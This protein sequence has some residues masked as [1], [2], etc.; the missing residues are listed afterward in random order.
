MRT[1]VQSLASLGGLRIWHYRV[2]WCKSLIWLGSCVLWLWCGLAATALIWPLAWELPHAECIPKKTNPPKTKQ[3]PKNPKN[4]PQREGERKEKALWLSQ[5]GPARWRL[6]FSAWDRGGWGS[7]LWLRKS[8]A[9]GFKR[10]QDGRMN[11]RTL[12]L[13]GC[14]IWRKPTVVWVVLSGDLSIL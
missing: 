9:V 5:G 8:I 1:Q 14:K 3:Q 13:I 11:D 6:W 4:N 10:P 12:G 7:L 2:L